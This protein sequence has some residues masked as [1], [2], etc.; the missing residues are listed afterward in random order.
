MLSLS[1]MQKRFQRHLLYGDTEIIEHIAPDR[2][3]TVKQ[4]LATYRNAYAARLIEA[5][6][7]DFPCLRAL[8]GED[9]FNTL[10]I[11]YIAQHPS[12]YTSLRWFGKHF[13]VYV[14]QHSNSHEQ[15]RLYD[16]AVMEWM[17]IDAF[18][19]PEQQTLDA[20]SMMTIPAEAWPAIKLTFHPSVFYFKT[21]WNTVA[22]WQALKSNKAAPE[23]DTIKS[24]ACLIWRQVLTTHYRVLDEDEAV[25]IEYAMQGASFEQLCDALT[26]FQ[27]T[28]PGEPEN[29]AMRSATL[30]K[31]WLDEGL[32]SRIN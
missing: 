1:D 20:I 4:R 12:S 5:L 16:L 15:Q 24:T 31:L 26:K 2:I 25:L 21:D 14:K 18:D 19:A 29:I 10:C 17:F 13:P 3:T 27:G 22:T 7:N 8:I 6:S 11:G 9:S 28:T 30:L 23:P 32:V